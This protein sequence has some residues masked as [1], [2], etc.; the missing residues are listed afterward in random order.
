MCQMDQRID[1]L[2][3][4]LPV[5]WCTDGQMDGHWMNGLMVKWMVWW[6]VGW[7]DG[8]MDGQTDGRMDRWMDVRMNGLLVRQTDDCWMDRHTDLIR[9]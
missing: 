5:R 7:T 3:Y 9:Q 1:G 8:Q 6:T 2:M 4:G